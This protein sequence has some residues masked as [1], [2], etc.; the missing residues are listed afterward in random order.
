MRT[1][2]G[3]W[4]AWAVL[5]GA[6]V[7]AV[8]LSWSPFPLNLQWSEAVFV[9]VLVCAALAG[10]LIPRE[11]HWLDGL[12]LVYL[13]SALPSLIASAE[14]AASALAYAKQLYVAIVYAVFAAVAAERWGALILARLMAG[15]A[16][17]VALV[18]LTAVG[19][20][21]AAHVELRW[22][23]ELV[24]I[25]YLGHVLRIKSTFY[26]VEYLA[27]F[28]A[29]T[30]P[31]TLGLA[32][33]ADRRVAR[34][35]WSGV[36][37]LSATAASFT[38]AHS[39]GGIL[40]AGLAFLWPYADRGRLRLARAAAV[41]GT[42]A[43]VVGLNLMLM[44]TIRQVRY[45]FGTDHAIGAP[46]YAYAFPGADGTSKLSLSVS[47]NPMSYLLLKR[48]AVAAFVSNPVTGVGLGTFR[49]ETER[50]FDEGRVHEQYRS[51]DPHSTWFGRL[52]ETGIAGA[53]GLTLLWV[54]VLR[55][56]V[57]AARSR[58]PTAWVPQAAFA[59][60]LGL[61]VNSLNVDIMN[62]RF[63]WVGLGLLRGAVG[64]K[65]PVPEA[66]GH[67]PRA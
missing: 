63:L 34:A 19:A 59:G 21:H 42:L 6:Y 27:N 47:Y 31:I 33:Q 45:E 29:L 53:T 50:A 37:A 67:A 18:G 11:R 62:F 57:A 65:A 2:R 64:A 10:R 20:Y 22:L 1:L 32:V 36:A 15:A 13:A 55:L 38:F 17:A 5:V 12:V 58:G 7:L 54:G 51:V 16:G 28:L 23:G 26:S 43:V 46:A 61:L 30:L 66:V 41:L 48:V 35:A 49:R 44:V 60:L 4:V 56:G 24:P 40:V 39:V 9:G 14:P 8:A 25:P 3:I 52:A